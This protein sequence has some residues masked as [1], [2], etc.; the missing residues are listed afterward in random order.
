MNGFLTPSA[1]RSRIYSIP[2]VRFAFLPTP[3]QYCPTLSRELGISL[4]VKRDDLTG[5]A[6]GGNKTRNLEFRMAEALSVGADVLVFGVE[7]SSNSARQTAAAANMIGL[8]LILILRGKPESSPQ[9]NLLCDLI[10]GADVR[11]VDVPTIHSLDPILKETAKELQRKGHRP[12]ILNH[13]KMFATGAALA[14]AECLLEILEQMDGRVPDYIYI[15]S[16]GK[17][18]AGLLLASKALGLQTHIVGIA[19][20]F[21]EDPWESAAR[22]ASETANLLGLDLMISPNEVENTLEYLGPGYGIPTPEGLRS[23]LLFARKEG[24]LLDP[25]YTGKAAAGLLDHVRK[26][27]VAPGSTVVFIHTGGQPALFAYSNS[28]T[29]FMQ[30]EASLSRGS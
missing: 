7:A 16:G 5:L 25:V 9:G 12:F 30:E 22:I 17:G 23:I 11:I 19:A 6:F 18:Q 29:R 2:R 27:K 20:T 8:P 4:W 13:G 28:L 3:L 21:N 15:S 26:G 10:L 14:Y 24:I 1:L